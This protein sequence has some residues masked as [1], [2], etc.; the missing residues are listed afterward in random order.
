ML[1]S[2][3]LC[4]TSAF[5]GGGLKVLVPPFTGEDGARQA[6]M[7]EMSVAF[8]AL[9]DVT[10]V[11]GEALWRELAAQ[12]TLSVA[13]PQSVAQVRRV[14]AALSAQWVLSGRVSRE[15]GRLVLVLML[16]GAT[17]RV[18]AAS[19]IERPPQGLGVTASRMA[20]RL[21]DLAFASLGVAAPPPPLPAPYPDVPVVTDSA[22]SEEQET[23]IDDAQPPTSAPI[24]AA[25]PRPVAPPAS[26]APAV[27]RSPPGPFSAPRFELSL[28]P[29]YV[30]F[31]EGD[32]T[33]SGFL[34]HGRLRVIPSV[35]GRTWARG[36]GF[37]VGVATALWTDGDVRFFEAVPTLFYEWRWDHGASVEVRTG[38][39]HRRASVTGGASL[40]IDSLSSSAW[41]V[42]GLAQWVGRR[43]LLRAI[44]ALHP[45]A[46][47]HTFGLSL[48][49]W[50]AARVGPMAIGLVSRGEVY[51]G[52]QGQL[53][54]IGLG[55]TLGF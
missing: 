5:A 15:G 50:A 13:W 20:Q 55:V 45:W 16:R 44:L 23:P 54:S 12:P 42:G 19:R 31:R 38:L 6:A 1:A 30:S 48:E 39:A 28:M 26:P 36:F 41:L 4:Q 10:V 35:G 11:G 14:L 46:S 52:R 25:P 51:T 37:E 47:E 9:A 43:F 40:P 18:V 7:A 3:V 21:R 53:Y 24:T 29:Q 22:E 8:G 32:L 2:W 17:G 33:G 49:G 27:R 34:V